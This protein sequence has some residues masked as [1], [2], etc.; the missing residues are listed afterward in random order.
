[1]GYYGN[2][3]GIVIILKSEWKLAMNYSRQR[4]LIWDAVTQ[5]GGH[6]TAEELKGYAENF[7]ECKKILSE[8]IAGIE[9]K[10][11]KHK[12]RA[13]DIFS[14]TEK[15]ALGKILRLLPE[16]SLSTYGIAALMRDFSLL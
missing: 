9:E 5:G 10:I 11:E 4:Q 1:M 6:P 3:S 7:D 2:K 13:E 16:L 14:K 15:N 12:K 8:K